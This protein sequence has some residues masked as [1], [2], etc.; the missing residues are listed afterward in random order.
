MPPDDKPTGAAPAPTEKKARKARVKPDGLEVKFLITDKSQI[1]TLTER[2]TA[3]QRTTDNY[4]QLLVYKA[5]KVAA[6]TTG[7]Q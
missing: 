7:A 5:C 6:P 4:A 2:A 1:A 3:D